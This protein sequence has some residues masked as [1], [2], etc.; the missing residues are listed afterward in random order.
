MTE[1]FWKILTALVECFFI[2]FILRFSLVFALEARLESF[3]LNVAG[4]YMLSGLAAIYA[5][6]QI[7]DSLIYK[8]FQERKQKALK[9]NSNEQ[10]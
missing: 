7:Q 2:G 8:Y 5:V 3:F 6:W 1:R 9:E 4:N 10:N